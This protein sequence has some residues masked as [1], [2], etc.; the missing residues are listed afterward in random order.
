VNALAAI[1]LPA[2]AAHEDKPANCCSPSSPVI[3]RAGRGGRP[4]LAIEQVF[5][6]AYQFT[7]AVDALEAAGHDATARELLNV[8]EQRFEPGSGAKDAAVN[9]GNCRRAFGA[10]HQRRGNALIQNEIRPKGF[11]FR[12]FG[13][14]RYALG[15]QTT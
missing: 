1:D 14:T 8:A 2:N 9:T 6:S 11:H 12:T 13:W 7:H 4:Y 3:G 15:F 5:P 10:L